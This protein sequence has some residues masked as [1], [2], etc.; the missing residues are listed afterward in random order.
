[1]RKAIS[2][3]MIFVFG[4][5]LWANQNVQKLKSENQR[6]KIMPEK[7][8][9]TSIASRTESYSLY[10]EDSYGD[11]WG[12]SY[13]D[14]AVN[15]VVVATGLTITTSDNGGNWN[16][17]N[18]SVEIGDVVATTWTSV[19]SW[20]SEASYGFF[21]TAG[22]LVAE[23]GTGGQPLLEVSFT[24]APPAVGV[25]FSEYAEG[26]S[27]NKYLEIYNGTDAA[28]DLTGLA[29]PNVSNDPN[30]VGEYEY[31]NTFPAGA[32]VA[33]G[34]VYV[35]AHGSA[36][37]AILAE[38][39][40]TFNYLSNGDDGYCLVVGA[41]GNYT[42]LDCIGDWNGDPGAGWEVAGV[43]DATK[44]HTLQ[45]KGRSYFR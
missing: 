25:W 37:A 36:D 27:N 30:V 9:S 33:P 34:D 3:L 35:I 12:G 29:F 18:F 40:H 43:A 8:Y 6:P 19:S 7:R 44:D 2:M 5:S 42:I 16:E 1:M 45:R 4:A 24:V 17:Y 23:A 38:A 13:L 10:M 20:D 14:L 15:G 21:N 41:E 39:D 31:W 26:S 11:G 22:D 32:T 28:V